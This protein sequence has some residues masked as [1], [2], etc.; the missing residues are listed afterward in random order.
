MRAWEPNTTDAASH[1]KRENLSAGSLL[2]GLIV[3]F[4]SWA[5]VVLVLY[6]IVVSK[7]GFFRI[8]AR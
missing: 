8:R 4:P 7:F 6:A 5:G 2:Y 1:E 3:A